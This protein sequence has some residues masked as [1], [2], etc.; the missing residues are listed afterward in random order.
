MTLLAIHFLGYQLSSSP[1]RFKDP[2]GRIFHPIDSHGNMNSNITTA[3]QPIARST[4]SAD[5][6]AHR[7]PTMTDQVRVAQRRRTMN[8][9]FTVTV[10]TG[11]DAEVFLVHDFLLKQ[12]SKFFQ[13][14]LKEEWREGQE[15]KVDLPEDKPE[16]FGVYTEWLLQGKITS[17]TGKPTEELT[18]YDVT[19][20]HLLL[21]D[22]YVAGRRVLG[23]RQ[24][25][26]V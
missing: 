20:E 9:V 6:S 23:T 22:L 13:T 26:L 16:A 18:S 8:N 4:P 5:T 1:D 7:T 10:G 15:K 19:L 3:L 2:P 21:A 12:S 11:D 25:E 24:E 14:A 17:G